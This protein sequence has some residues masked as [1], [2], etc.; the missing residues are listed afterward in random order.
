MKLLKGLFLSSICMVFF[1]LNLTG[2]T[3]FSNGLLVSSQ[4]QINNFA[5]NYPDCTEITGYLIIDMGANT[6]PS[7]A[8]LSQITAVGGNLVVRE[9]YNLTSLNGLH[10]ITTVGGSVD[11]MDNDNL[12]SLG[13]LAS[14]TT[15]GGDFDITLNSSITNL[16]GLSNLISVDGSLSI[17]SNQ[18]ITNFSGLTNLSSIGGW[19]VVFSNFSLQNLSGMNNLTSIGDFLHIRD[20]Y[21]IVNLGGLEGITSI[22]GEVF[23]DNN[24]SLNNLTGL[25]NLTTVGEKLD[26][27]ENYALTSLQGLNSLQSVGGQFRVTDNNLITSFSALANLETIGSHCVI[28]RI[29]NLTSLN[30]LDNLTSIGEAFSMIEIDGPTSL[31]GLGALQSVGDIFRINNCAD[32]Q[33]LAG[34]NSLSILGGDLII[35]ANPDLVNLTGLSGITEVPGDVEIIWNLD[36]TSLTGLENLETI[37]GNLK[38]SSLD[39]TSFDGFQGLTSVGGTIDVIDNDFL[40]SLDGLGNLNFIGDYL[41]IN[42]NDVLYDWSGM[43]ALDTVG[44]Y[45]VINGVETFFELEG[46]NNLSYVGGYLDISDHVNLHSIEGF[47]NLVNVGGFLKLDGQIDDITGFNNLEYVGEY[48]QFNGGADLQT[49]NAFENIKAIGGYLSLNNNDKLKVV[50]GFYQLDSIGGNLS[51]TNNDSLES[52]IFLNELNYIN[53]NVVLSDNASL[54]DI[55]G[56]FNYP[57]QEISSIT[58]SDNPILSTC[59]S[60]FLCNY[61]AIGNNAN[62]NN[63]ASGCSSE[64]EVLS[65]C[66]AEN[67]L[68]YTIDYKLFYDLNQDGLQDQGEP[69]Y[70]D[71]SAI[72]SPTPGITFPLTGAS[73]FY[74]FGPGTYSISYNSTNTPNWQLTSDSASFTITL[75]EVSQEGQACFGLFPSTLESGLVS[76]VS[77]PPAR[78]NEFVTFDLLVK[79]VGSTIA[80]GTAWLTLDDDVSNIVFEVQPDTLIPP[81]TVGWFFEDLFPGHSL[82][83]EFG[84]DVPGPP[85]FLPGETLAFYSTIDFQDEN[86]V[87]ATDNDAYITPILCSY[88]PNDKLVFPNRS[89]NLTLFGEDL[90]YTIRFQNTGNDYAY[91]VTIRDTLDANLDVSSFRVLGSSHYDILQTTIEDDQFLSFHF[92]NI[93]LPD[94]TTN[95]EGSQGY[96]TYLIRGNDG[97][98]ENTLI[99]NS[100]GIYFDQNPPIITNTTESVMVSELLVGVFIPEGNNEWDIT[101]FP[102][103]TTGR[104]HL[105]GELNGA[106]VIMMDYTGRVV[107][108]RMTEGETSIDLGGLPQGVYFLHLL[109]EKGRYVEKILKF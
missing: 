35:E 109:S 88:D 81:Y 80:S 27:D 100:A 36:Q 29:N 48:L 94:S 49:M 18:S 31:A 95:F 15:V 33:S 22:P 46:F 43:T 86:G 53:G 23:I 1:A 16:L 70:P 41:N 106:E 42:Y 60:Q 13:G 3:C 58:I 19:L 2:Q 85:E 66:D 82:S 52:L 79:N 56:L 9:S 7:L 91:D 69:V 54:A 76:M 14:L 61:L 96:V 12:T 6:N 93:F 10:N 55:S 32:I 68:L 101:V 21:N 8:G 20:N 57:F 107:H 87:Q 104:V 26:I 47:S 84:F 74:P 99:T 30:G 25:N 67:I 71:A 50:N 28:S 78:C 92:P 5:T 63:N 24:F 77:G 37:G 89:G 75:N 34:L 39:I 105:G 83:N 40:T 98:D 90:I 97:L 103:P 62:I 73:T 4:S 38:V 11:I 64:S 108:Q 51:I 72:V 17:V 65:E 59:T 44:G 45:M 102:N